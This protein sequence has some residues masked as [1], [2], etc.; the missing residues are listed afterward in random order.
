[1]NPIVKPHYTTKTAPKNCKTIA[2]FEKWV[3]RELHKAKSDL[4]YD[5]GR[6][7]YEKPTKRNQT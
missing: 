6:S 4:Y 1:M 2:S 7:Y 5:F 3:K